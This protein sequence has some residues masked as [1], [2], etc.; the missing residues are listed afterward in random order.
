M[1]ARRQ[2]G[3]PGALPMRHRAVALGVVLLVVAGCSDDTSAEP[4]AAATQAPATTQ[5]AAESTTSLLPAAA[6][7]ATA[8][9]EPGNCTYLG[10]AVIPRGTNATFEFD[11]GGHDSFVVVALTI[12]GVTREEIIEYNETH[13]G[14]NAG[15]MVTPYFVAGPVFYQEGAGQMVVEFRDDGDWHVVCGTT[16][17]STNTSYLGGMIKVI[18]G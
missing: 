13:G 4:A 1:T 10:P 9:Y 8:V 12:D 11:D 5:P 15:P 6:V 16:P 2:N 17:R 14:P 3:I 7:D 18:A